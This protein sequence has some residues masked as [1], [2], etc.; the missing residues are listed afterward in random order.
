MKNLFLKDFERFSVK[1]SLCKKKILLCCSYNSRK[2]NISN[3]LDILGKTLDLQISKY[4]FLIAC[5]YNLET[6][7]TVMRNCCDMYNLH[8]LSKISCSMKSK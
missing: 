7:E 5:G 6:S 3:H 2:I 8:N 4:N 1:L